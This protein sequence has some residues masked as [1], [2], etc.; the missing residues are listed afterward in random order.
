MKLDSCPNCDGSLRTTAKTCSDCGLELRA[1]FDASPIVS[2]PAEDQEFLL[3]F[4]LASGNFKALGEKLDLSYP[5]LRSRL[6]KIIAK[7]ESPSKSP[8]DILRDI[9]RGNITPEAAIGQLRKMA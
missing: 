6:D 7:L 1:D 9:N 4:I 5:T 2:L 8:D 3:Q